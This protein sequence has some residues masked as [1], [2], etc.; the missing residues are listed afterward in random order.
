MSSKKLTVEQVAD[1][2]QLTTQTIRNWIRSGQLPAVKL[3]Y[4]FRIE[5]EDLDA[6]VARHRGGTTSL[7]SHRDPWTPETLGAPYRPQGDKR[8]PSVWDGTDS[9]ILLPKRS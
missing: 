4:I 7:G 8:Q 6:M 1:E 2:L 5:R 3:G 9:P